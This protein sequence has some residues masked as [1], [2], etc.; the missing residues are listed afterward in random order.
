MKRPRCK[1][2]VWH[3]NIS[4]DVDTTWAVFLMKFVWRWRCQPSNYPD[5]GQTADLASK[6]YLLERLDCENHRGVS[7]ARCTVNIMVVL[8][9]VKLLLMQTI[10]S[11]CS[12]ILNAL[13]GWNK[14]DVSVNASLCLITELSSGTMTSLSFIVIESVC[15]HEQ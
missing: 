15:C 5:P 11:S 6:L 4:L 9:S 13:N 1:N 2:L 7:G 10:S 12:S 14:R 8:E 3:I